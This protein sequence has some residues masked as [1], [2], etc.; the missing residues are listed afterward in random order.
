MRSFVWKYGTD[1]R[2][3]QITRHG[4]ALSVGRK[5]RC[6]S[7]HYKAR[8]DELLAIKQYILDLDPATVEVSFAIETAKRIDGLGVPGASGL[9]ALLFPS[10]FWTVDF[11]LVKTLKEVTGLA[12]EARVMQMSGKALTTDDA[13]VLTTIMRRKALENAGKFDDP[14]WTPRKIDMVLWA[15]REKAKCDQLR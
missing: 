5:S 1:P 11:F 8:P 4:R 3:L 7:S 15:T 2:R 14:T 13:V 9:L 12:E 10:Y 6:L